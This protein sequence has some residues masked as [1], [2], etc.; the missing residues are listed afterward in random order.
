[1]G[2]AEVVAIVAAGASVAASTFAAM[3]L[4]LSTRDR[5][6]ARAAEIDGVAVAWHPTVRPNHPDP[7]GNAAW[8]YEVV[9]QN[10]GR[11]PI[12]AVEVTLH[13]AGQFQ[14]LHYDG[15][16]QPVTELVLVEPVIL[17]SSRRTWRRTL[18]LPFDQG[19]LLSQTT[20]SIAFTPATGGRHVNH[21]D[22]RAPEVLRHT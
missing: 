7:E 20:A 6:E 18:V 12:R 8:T 5:R 1:M 3:E 21:M 10:P 11:L 22:G 9:A 4:R 17:A 15:A 2:T 19:H 14:R 13:L 16:L